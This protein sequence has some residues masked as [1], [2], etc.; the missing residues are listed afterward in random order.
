MFRYIL[1]IIALLA[2]RC[3]KTEFFGAGRNSADDNTRSS[4]SAQNP[5]PQAPGTP[6]VVPA[7]GNNPAIIPPVPPLTSAPG[8]PPIISNYDR[9]PYNPTFPNI[10]SA[11]GNPYGAS[12]VYPNGQPFIPNI[13]SPNGTYPQPAPNPFTAPNPQINPSDPAIPGGA[14]VTP[15][16]NPDITV[17][18][19][20]HIIFGDHSVYH[21]G[22]GNASGTSCPEEVLQVP[23]VGSRFYFQFEVLTDNTIVNIS[24]GKICGVDLSL[25][26][27]IS[28][29]TLSQGLLGQTRLTPAA[30][31]MGYI[32]PL[33]QKTFAKG[34]YWLVIDSTAKKIESDNA[35]VTMGDK[36]D[37]LVGKIH[38][39]ANQ[40]IK[41]GIAG[42]ANL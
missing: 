26:N 40:P 9:N 21:I 37:F 6:P 39:N 12:P 2:V 25:S 31:R 36:D 38:I 13:L 15:L 24:I 8:Q 19:P 10:P 7:P 32:S 42:P 35:A 23:V 11:F 5:N 22:D 29:G 1:F 16:A 28:I 18:T 3:G 17:V 30:S 4:T 34:Q 27:F 33:V 41:P 14:P 20:N